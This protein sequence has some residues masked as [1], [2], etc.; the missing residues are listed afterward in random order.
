MWVSTEA[1]TH[2]DVLHVHIGHL[3]HTGPTPVPCDDAAVRHA[4]ERT[5]MGPRTKK[6]ILFLVLA[7]FIYAIFTSPDQAA[8][9]ITSIWNILVQG[10][11]ALLE[12]FD[13]LLGG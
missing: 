2:P 3:R 8:G 12:F 10:F 5:T 1:Q 13:S 4:E 11:Y 7:F 9:I 6:V